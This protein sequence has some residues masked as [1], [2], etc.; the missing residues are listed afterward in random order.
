[1]PIMNLLRKKSAKKK[2]S[3]SQSF[4][5]YPGINL[6]KKRDHHSKNL[7]IRISFK[8]ILEG[9]TISNLMIR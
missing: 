3:H 1:M 6:I 4:K 9:G 5:K 8:E 2:K 7:K